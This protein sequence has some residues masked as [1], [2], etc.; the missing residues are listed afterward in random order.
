MPGGPI[1]TIASPVSAASIMQRTAAS[2]PWNRAF[3]AV[4]KASNLSSVARLVL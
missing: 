3:N 4:S 2:S 1:I